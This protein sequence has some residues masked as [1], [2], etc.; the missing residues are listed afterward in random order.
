[1]NFAPRLPIPPRMS[2][3]L[4]LVCPHCEKINRIT[5]MRLGEAPKCGH[6]HQSLFT[7]HPIELTTA[8]FRRQVEHS[9]VPI[10]VDFW[11]PWCG[12]CQMMAPQFAAAAAELEP[13]ARLAKVNTDVETSLASEF[14][15]R[16]IPTLALFKGGREVARQA[17][18]M[19][20][21]DIIRWVR[22]RA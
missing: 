1:M 10:V 3:T 7:G 20:K 4:H 12:P 2:D 16:S 8:S 5:T 15:I 6:C 22:E 13:T 19:G 18:A 14:G 9:Q 21:S 17:G 11:A